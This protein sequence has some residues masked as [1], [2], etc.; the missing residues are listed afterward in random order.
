MKN[1]KR[2]PSFSEREMIIRENKPMRMGGEVGIFSAPVSYRENMNAH[3]FGKEPYF[4]ASFIDTDGI[5]SKHYNDNL[6]RPFGHDAVDCFG[7]PWKWVES[8]GGSITPGGNPIFEDANE[9]KDH[10][11]IPDI[12]KWDWEEDS[13]IQPDP[14]YS[15]VF[16]FVNGFWFE[17]LISL[18]DFD[19][20]AIALVDSEQQDAVREFFGAMNDLALKL[21][22]KICEYYPGVDG[23]CVHDDWGAQRA[24]FFSDEVATEMFLPF[25][26]EFVD[27]VHAKGRYCTI[28]SCG[29]I[30]DRVHIFVEAGLDG[31]EMMNC[32]DVRRLYDEFGEELCF[33]A[34]PMAFDPADDMAAKASARE[35][36]D[37]FC[38]PGKPTMLG[39]N[40]GQALGSEAFRTELYEDSRKKYLGLC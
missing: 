10:V 3:F 40:A 19:N 1:I 12:D 11:V 24:P 8:A 15:G 27:H 7:V 9:W 26:K 2:K 21:V 5:M 34:W 33:Q 16:T 17:R 20:A 28:H 38:K 22:D 6:S 18:M 32:N 14:K 35:F 4:A 29:M 36:V 31:W 39:Y 37:Y 25:M 13:K 30:E 23:F